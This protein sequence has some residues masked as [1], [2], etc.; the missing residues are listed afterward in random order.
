MTTSQPFRIVR[1]VCGG[2]DIHKTKIQ[3]AVQSLDRETMET[4]S[5]TEAFGT[6][7]ADLDEMCRWLLSRGCDD[8]AMESTGKYWIPVADAL[9]RNRIR[10]KLVH[11]K[12][13]KAVLGK[14]TDK[15]DAVFI[16]SMHACDLCGKGSVVFC[17]YERACRDLMRR[18]WK[19]GCE[20]AAEKNRMQNCMTVPGLA[21]DQ[22]FS[23][24]LGDSARKVMDAVLGDKQADDETLL[25]L[26]HKN[27]KKADRLLDAVHK[28]S[29]RP[30][31][32]FK[33]KDIKGH[34]QELESHRA[35]ILEQVMLRLAAHTAVLQL[36]A[37]VPGI[38]I[39]AAAMIVCEVGLDMSRWDGARQFVNWLGLAPRCNESNGRKKP[40]RI[41]KAGT[42]IK[43]L[44][45]QC[46]LSAIKDPDG[47]YGIKYRRIK[48]RR[49]H[50][51]AVIAIA[52]MMMVAVYHIVKDR[53]PFSPVDYAGATDPEKGKKKKMTVEDA[54]RFLMEKNMVVSFSDTEVTLKGS[55]PPI[56]EAAA[57]SAA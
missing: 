30:D 53:K 14:K 34:I 2:L 6:F 23:D 32:K 41:S 56:C 48:R 1:P 3:A 51:K 50:K 42:Y 13:V 10:F 55:P 19:L 43:P 18:Y 35:K 57:S 52:R 45:V 4:S 49:G 38:G 46:A 12:Y 21:L 37:G 22:V 11:P 40:A 31:Q 28:S 7:P 20:P 47:Y 8:V 33:M 24:P 9:E 27:C 5:E 39:L 15:K 29:I 16:A 36:I 17:S 44:L 54:I 25:S 26:L